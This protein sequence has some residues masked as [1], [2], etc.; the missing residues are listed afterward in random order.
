MAIPVYP[1]F[2]PLEREDKEL[3]ESYYSSRRIEISD[4]AFANYFIW[5]KLDRAQLTLAA[6][7][8]CPLVI[9]PGRKP[10]F[11]MPLGGGDLKEAVKICLG[12]TGSVIR[13]DDHFKEALGLEGYFEIS[14]DRDNFDYVYPVKDLAELKGRKY[15]GK[16]NHINA[17]LKVNDYSYEKM[18]DRHIP[19]C[20]ELND[21][22]CRSKKKETEEFPNLECEADAVREALLNREFLDLIGGVVSVKGRIAAFCL[23]QRL[24]DDTAVIHIEKSDPFLRGAAQLINRDFARNELAGFTYV[25]REQDMGH[26]GLRR[27]KLS[28]H[29]VE[30][31]RKYNIRMKYE[32]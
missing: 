21:Q 3:F 32:G 17:F 14:E 30:L 1:D 6:G 18:K 5:R 27:A 16:R 9:G 23:G 10:H 20:I 19:E 24:T 15:D 11:M 22:W 25:N 8:L 31:R 28:Y 26:P 29:P 12:H 13:V 2:K 4:H 7:C